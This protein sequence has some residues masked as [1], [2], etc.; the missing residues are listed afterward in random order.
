MFCTGCGQF[1]LFASNHYTEHRIRDFPAWGRRC[2]LSVRVVRAR[3]AGCAWKSS[4]GW[5]APV[6][7]VR[8]EK[9]IARLCDYFPVLDVAEIEGIDKNTVYR[10]DRKWLAHCKER[11]VS[12][13]FRR[14]SRKN[15]RNVVAVFMDLGTPF[16]NSVRRPCPK[17]VVVFD[18]FHVF[19]YLL[20]AVE[21]VRRCE[22]AALPEKE[23]KFIKGKRWLWLKPGDKFKRKQ[24]Q[25]L[26]EIMKQNA[27]RHA[28]AGL[29]AQE[30]FPQLLRP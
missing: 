3:T 12:G 17:A 29:P 23:G 5:R 10:I 2:Y 4:T 6:G 24:K 8:Y 22:Q 25:T 21:E 27:E 11:A 15:C 19:K 9:Y 28:P 16:L 26:D 20:D 13:F 14:W 30:R 18:K 7:A 1:M